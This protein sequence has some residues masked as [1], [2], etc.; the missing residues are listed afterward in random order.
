MSAAM[1]ESTES[2]VRELRE[3][4]SV[5]RQIVLI[6]PRHSSSQDEERE[7]E[8]Q[9]DAVPEDNLSS[10]AAV[11]EA[12]L[13]RDDFQ[14]KPSQDGLL[15]KT[16]EEST[17]WKQ[18]PEDGEAWSKN[19]MDQCFPGLEYLTRQG[20]FGLREVSQQHQRLLQQRWLGHALAE[21]PDLFDDELIGPQDEQDA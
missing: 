16:V 21:H 5:M 17:S 18:K 6:A 10:V 9:V 14:Q 2:I 11:S 4:H 20:A 3:I 19:S 1:I 13:K 12:Q 8:Q 15:L 7:D